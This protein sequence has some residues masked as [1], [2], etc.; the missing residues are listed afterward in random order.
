MRFFLLFL[1][2]IGKCFLVSA[3][4]ILP[5]WIKYTSS[6][7]IYDFQ[8]DLNNNQPENIFLNNLT[9]NTR[10]NLAKQLQVKIKEVSSLKKETDDGHSSIK[11]SS[12]T[13]FH[14]DI[15]LQLVNTKTFYDSNTNKGYVI[16]YINKNEAKN[17]CKNE[18][19]KIINNTNIDLS[20]I[21][22]LIKND[23]KFKAKEE[24]DKILNK[25]EEC[26]KLLIKL[27][28]FGINKDEYINL[29]SD[30]GKI[31]KEIKD[32]KIGMDYGTILYI[33]C[34][35]EIFGED[36]LMLNEEL[37]GLLAD[38]M[39]SFTNDLNKADWI[40]RINANARKLNFQC[41]NSQSFYFTM[42]DSKISIYKSRTSQLV[43]ENKISTKGGHTI[44]Y[45][46]AALA[47]YSK[48]SKQLSNIIIK[49]IKQ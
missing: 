35:A 3:Q 21:Y 25:V 47:A 48:L 9:N 28:L 10:A 36:N 13:I 29:S 2:I 45:N 31:K 44:N 46:E 14:T 6:E 24:I 23:S 27:N 33:I 39:I 1:F 17:Y 15:D 22:T 5:E 30:L 43:Y 32:L 38:P 19:L 11:Y 26:D 4:K 12:N 34:N 42:V 37:K 20:V 49:Y 41:I 16:S 18:I 40:I 8:T 7:Y